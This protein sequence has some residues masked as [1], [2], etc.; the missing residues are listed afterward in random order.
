MIGSRRRRARD[1]RQDSNNPRG[2]R[3]TRTAAGA[4]A[5]TV[6][7][8]VG[9]FGVGSGTQAAAN[10][11]EDLDIGQITEL[12]DNEI[13]QQYITQ[14]VGPEGSTPV[15]DPAAPPK[16]VVDC[17]QSTGTGVA[18]VL[19]GS[20]E[21]GTAA[22]S[23]TVA[24]PLF[25]DRNLIEIVSAAAIDP[26]G[27]AVNPLSLGKYKT[28]AQVQSDAALPVNVQTV[29]ECSGVLLGSFCL[30]SWRNRTYDVN[31]A[32]RTEALKVAEYLTGTKYDYTKPITLPGAADP[33]GSATIA[34]SGIHFALAMTGGNAKAETGNDLSIATAGASDGRN[35]T[36]YSYLGMA[37]ALNMDTDQVK[38][39]WFGKELDFT[40]LEKSGLLGLAGDDAGELI[41]TIE[42]VQLPALKEVSCF[43]LVAQATAEGLGSCSNV[44]GTFDTYQ[45]L[46]A[47]VVGESRQTQYALTD[48]TSLVLGNDALLKQLTGSSESTP[49]MDSLMENLT[50]EEGRLKFAKDFVR[51]TQDVTTVA[52]ERQVIGEDGVPVVD[53]NGDPV[54][55][56]V[57]KTVTAAYLTSDYGLRNPVTIEWLGHRMVLF[58]AVTVNGQERPN[59]LG[60]PEIERIV[61]DADRGLLPKVSLIHID[62]PFGLGTLTLDK[63]FDIAHTL[64]NYAST[65]TL[66][67]DI[68]QVG[69]LV[70]GL[71]GSDE[72]PTTDND[73]PTTASAPAE[74]YKRSAPV[75][76]TT[77]STTKVKVPATSTTRADEPVEDAPT[78][79]TTVVT[80]TVPT[81]ESATPDE[82]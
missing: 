41:D 52:E 74:I 33:E 47:P 73:A 10:P 4:M 11:L 22:E 28:Y 23:M 8:G 82:S 78:S 66:P 60:L 58:P 68:R 7:L 45:D 72:Q 63:P 12:L 46:R 19:P 37:N 40:N 30:G 42:G 13:L 56:Q 29:R 21:V 62:N 16:A 44:L 65:V 50:S 75:T 48:V 18:V 14:C 15:T 34:G 9:L 32:K 77:S 79:T 1:E 25:G 80:T 71:T 55:E 69:D 26:W 5:A 70:G 35:S 54:M 81:T 3:R 2:M 61:D 24:L 36:S 17:S 27:G 49:F 59:Y 57:T 51:F 39:T 76:S 20:I 6:L 38:L 67:G 43:G 64:R 53:E 31:L